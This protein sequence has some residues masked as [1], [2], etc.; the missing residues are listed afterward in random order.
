MKRRTP[1]RAAT[2]RGGLPAKSL[3]MEAYSRFAGWRRGR[4]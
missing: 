4:T 2:A 1:A 3:Q